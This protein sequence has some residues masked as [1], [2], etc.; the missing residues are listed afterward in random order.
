LTKE[1]LKIVP[2]N[3]KK[4]I[5]KNSSAEFRRILETKPLEIVL[6]NSAEF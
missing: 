5:N 1:L 4:K 6:Q 2:Q 3:L